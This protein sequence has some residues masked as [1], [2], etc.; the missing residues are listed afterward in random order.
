MGAGI[1][2]RVGLCAAI[3]IALSNSGLYSMSRLPSMPQDAETIAF[4]AVVESSGRQAPRGKPA[5]HYRVHRADPGAGEHRDSCLGDHRH[6]DHHTVA[7]A[8]AELGS[9]PANRATSSRS[10]A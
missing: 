7:V 6:V 9:T 4:G 2:H 3:S 1:T 8:H 10:C 5:E